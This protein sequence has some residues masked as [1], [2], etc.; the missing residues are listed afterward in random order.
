M[1]IAIDVRKLHDF[2]VGTYVRN[3]VRWL[4]RL[5][6]ESEYV[7]LCRREDCDQIEQLGPN[8]RPMPDRSPNYSVAEQFTVPFDLARVRAD[9]FHAP[10]YVLP[11]LTP[12]R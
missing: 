12:C 10:H 2:G 11:A 9:L 6:R 8:F 4:A 5:D 7:L 1:R 3:L